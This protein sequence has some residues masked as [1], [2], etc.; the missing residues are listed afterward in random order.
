MLAEAFRNTGSPMR[1]CPSF[2]LALDIRSNAFP[3]NLT[4]KQKDD[5][6]NRARGAASHKDPKT[7]SRWRSAWLFFAI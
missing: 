5:K 2:R 3:F 1:D 7:A 6:N 4:A